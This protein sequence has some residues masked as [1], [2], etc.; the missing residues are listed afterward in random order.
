MFK[1]LFFLIIV[2]AAGFAAWNA[3]HPAPV[4]AADP[5][6]AV[7]E[8]DNSFTGRMKQKVGRFSA[9]LAE[10]TIRASVAKTERQLALL[11]PAMKRAGGQA[12][13]RSI[14][15]AKKIAVLDSLSLAS[16][17]AAHPISAVKQAM[18]ARGYIDVIRQ[19][20]MEET[21]VR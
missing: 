4:A 1:R 3:A 20:L 2:G 18:G 13:R 12:E 6:A 21:A 8:I 9:N 16:L 14:V 10:N 19:D 5:T 11:R 7:E 17:E 15:V